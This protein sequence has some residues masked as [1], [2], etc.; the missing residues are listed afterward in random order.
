MPQNDKGYQ[1]IAEEANRLSLNTIPNLPNLWESDLKYRDKAILMRED[2]PACFGWCIRRIG[3]AIFDPRMKYSTYSV[4]ENAKLP[5]THFYWYD[6]ENL[7]ELAARE[8]VEV[9]TS[10]GCEEI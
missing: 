7:R 2:A 9:L 6:G 8:L 10:S 5:E 4:I 1:A 3:T